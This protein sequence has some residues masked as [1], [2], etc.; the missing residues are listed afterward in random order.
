LGLIGIPHS[1]TLQRVT[2][3]ELVAVADVDPKHQATVASLLEE[4]NVL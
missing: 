1:Q 4:Q 3:C 2:E